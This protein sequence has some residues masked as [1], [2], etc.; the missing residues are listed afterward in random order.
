MYFLIYW[1]ASW[2]DQLYLLDMRLV[3]GTDRYLYFT[4]D[5]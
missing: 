4:A 2:F 3:S 5:N 1:D